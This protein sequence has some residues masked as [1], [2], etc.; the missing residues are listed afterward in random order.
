MMNV[1]SFKNLIKPV[2]QLFVVSMLLLAA[3][4]SA[5]TS[6]GTT[7]ALPEGARVNKDKCLGYEMDYKKY[8]KPVIAK[9]QADMYQLYHQDAD[10]KHDAG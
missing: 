2:A 4:A 10:W 9:V 8:P 7:Q 5:Q 3:I 1:A 6:L